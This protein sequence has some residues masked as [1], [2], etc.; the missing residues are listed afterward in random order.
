MKNYQSPRWLDCALAGLLGFLF[1]TH[2]YIATLD[3]DIVTTKYTPVTE[4]QTIYVD[5]RR[6]TD[7]E[8]AFTSATNNSAI[9]VGPGTYQIR[10]YDWADL[11]TVASI[12]NTYVRLTGVTN[13]QL[14]GIGRPVLYQ[15]N[16]GVG[17]MF[18]EVTNVHVSGITFRGFRTNNFATVPVVTTEQKLPMGLAF[19]RTNR[20]VTIRD[21]HFEHHEGSAIHATSGGTGAGNERMRTTD[22]LIDGCR[23]I[24]CG[25]T[26]WSGL[27]EGGILQCHSKT[28]YINNHSYGHSRGIEA[29]SE[30]AGDRIDDVLIANST[31]EAGWGYDIFQVDAIPHS[32]F[33]LLNNMFITDVSRKQSSFHSVVFL[34][35][36][37]SIVSGNTWS[38]F[39]GVN[40]SCMELDSQTT[41]IT[42]FIFSGNTISGCGG[43]GLAFFNGSARMDR[44]VITG[45]TFDTVGLDCIRGNAFDMLIANNLF[46]NWGTNSTPNNAVEMEDA[47]HSGTNVTIRGNVF[48]TS[49]SAN[50]AV[51]IQAGSQDVRLIDNT[52]VMAGTKIADAGTRTSIMDNPRVFSGTADFADTGPGSSTFV[53][54]TAAGVQSN[55]W[56]QVVFPHQFLTSTVSN[57]SLHSFCSNGSVW[58]QFINNNLLGSQDPE[59]TP[60]V[61]AIVRQV[62]PY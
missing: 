60:N 59:S 42:N 15:T 54:I 40:V 7:F 16:R 8:T 36:L 18:G 46:Y 62:A 39:W 34:N 55:D 32:G 14:L 30:L 11:D 13:V 6:Y 3:A 51:D 31:F 38:N 41:G 5:G 21:C 19:W 22:L 37:N 24:E 58:I 47:F 2:G 61:R 33:R 52:Y 49:G 10:A 57:F 28:R 9:V 45:N 48:N 23:F 20:H 17:V 26:N 4:R 27:L 53:Q 44:F 56:S 35:T 29:Y 43:W 25:L 1:L 50:R 12:G